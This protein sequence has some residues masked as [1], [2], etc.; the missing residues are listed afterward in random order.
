MA[1]NDIYNSPHKEED[2]KDVI[3]K[4]VKTYLKELI[5]KREKEEKDMLERQSKLS[6]N[7]EQKRVNTDKEEDKTTIE[8]YT[9]LNVKRAYNLY[10]LNETETT[11]KKSELVIENTEKEIREMEVEFPD[12]KK[13]YLDR[14]IEAVKKAGNP[15]ES[16]TF[17]KHMI[18]EEEMM[19]VKR[20][21][22]EAKSVVI[23]E[24]E[25]KKEI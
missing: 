25:E 23:E 21:L 16:D 10:H 24:V 15:E 9:L 1:T 8:Y 14:F 3:S 18:D 6:L 22:Q 2:L 13:E 7:K 4:V 11:M 12:F 5:E 20:A 19:I 17:I